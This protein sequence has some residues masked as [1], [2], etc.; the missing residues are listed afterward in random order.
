MHGLKYTT[1]SSKLQSSL[2]QSF[3]L[4]GSDVVNARLSMSMGPENFAIW[5][6]KMFKLLAQEGVH[7]FGTVNIL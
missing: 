4:C 5:R 1:G 7:Y 3:I 2:N 6:D